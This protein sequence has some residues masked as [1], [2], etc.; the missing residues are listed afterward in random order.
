MADPYERAFVA[1]LE[2]RLTGQAPLIQVL[3]GPRQ[4]GKTTGM[5]QLL[6]ASRAIPITPMPMTC[7]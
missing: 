6:A 2:K 1:Q 7:W 4:V 3:V 5:R